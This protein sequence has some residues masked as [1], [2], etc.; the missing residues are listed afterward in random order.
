M[1]NYGYRLDNGRNIV[2]RNGVDLL[3]DGQKTVPLTLEEKWFALRL[4]FEEQGSVPEFFSEDEQEE[5]P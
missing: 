4:Y 1:A 5:I 2:C 3:I